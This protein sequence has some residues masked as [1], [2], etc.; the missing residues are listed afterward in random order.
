[1]TPSRCNVT[2]A[3]CRTSRGPS[4]RDGAGR[5]ESTEPGVRW[6]DSG[7]TLDG[8]SAKLRARGTAACVRASSDRSRDSCPC[9]DGGA[10]SAARGASCASA[11]SS[12]PASISSPCLTIARPIAPA[13]SRPVAYRSSRAGDSAFSA[14]CSSSAGMSSA[15]VVGGSTIAERTMSSR[16]SP[17]RP[18]CI[19]RPTSTSQRMTPSA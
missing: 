9:E 2:M 13:I 12:A 6:D 15:C 14:I 4:W 7:R 17:P 3:T 5:L 1:M 18:P 11:L 16:A 8:G 10:L 19:G